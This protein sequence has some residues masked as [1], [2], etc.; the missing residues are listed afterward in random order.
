MQQNST[1]LF[2]VFLNKFCRKRKVRKHSHPLTTINKHKLSTI[3]DKTTSFVTELATG[4]ARIR[5]KTPEILEQ[6]NK[7]TKSRMDLVQKCPQ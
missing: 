1:I 4:D 2:E 7:E 6:N 5:P 3:K